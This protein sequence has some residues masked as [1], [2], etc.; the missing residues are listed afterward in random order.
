MAKHAAKSQKS[1]FDESEPETQPEKRVTAQNV[2]PAGVEAAGFASV[3]FDADQSPDSGPRISFRAAHGTT[4]AS[5][6]D[7]QRQVASRP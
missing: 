6:C 5:D 2:E 4:V 1:L 7:W 3:V